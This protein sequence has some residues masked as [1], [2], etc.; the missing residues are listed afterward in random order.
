MPI[1]GHIDAGSATQRACTKSQGYGMQ[2]TFPQLLFQ[3]AVQ[4]PGD[5]AMREKEY[6]IWQA[7]S[8]ADLATMVSRAWKLNRRE[9]T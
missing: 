7:L 5:A 9:N 8:W 1:I 6:G 4:R 3:H 2:T